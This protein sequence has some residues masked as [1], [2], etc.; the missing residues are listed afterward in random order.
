MKLVNNIGSDTYN[1]QTNEDMMKI[2]N[3]EKYSKLK[4]YNH[5]KELR[6]KALQES[7]MVYHPFVSTCNS[8]TSYK[9]SEIYQ[10]FCQ[11]GYNLQKKMYN[12]FEN[13]IRKPYYMFKNRDI[14]EDKKVLKM[15]N[16]S[17]SYAVYSKS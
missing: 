6:L 15:N 14:K 12:L 7:A 17:F 8:R 2:Y 13:F 5:S 3:I 9:E 10:S 11:S 1:I 4:R 16:S